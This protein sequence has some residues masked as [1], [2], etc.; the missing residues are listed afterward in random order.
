[1][2]RKSFWDNIPTDCK[3]AITELKRMRVY[4]LMALDYEETFADIWWL[5]LHEV[6]MY[7]EGEF[8]R[9][10]SRC[11]FGTGDPQAMNLKQAQA[12][13]KW[14]IRWLPLFNK[15]KQEQYLS[16]YWHMIHGVG[17]REGDYPYGGQLI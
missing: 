7:N 13:D 9:E 11:I 3:K 15:Y 4:K 10:A 14:L 6:D 16:E 2:E 1:M 17:F 12:A 5:V 8:C